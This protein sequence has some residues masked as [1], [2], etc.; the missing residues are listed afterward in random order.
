[1]KVIGEVMLI[2]CNL[3]ELLLKVVCFLEF[4]IYYLELDYLKEF[5]KEMMKKCIIKV[6]DE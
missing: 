2:G 6:D 5:D 3:E 4:G 1:M